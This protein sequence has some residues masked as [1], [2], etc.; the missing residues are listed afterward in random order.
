[1]GMKFL[2]YEV[3]LSSALAD[4]G[5]MFAKIFFKMIVSI[6]T[7]SGVYEEFHCSSPKPNIVNLKILAIV[8]GR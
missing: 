3:C 1:M 5:K 8:V 2:S 4:N 6:Y 7:L